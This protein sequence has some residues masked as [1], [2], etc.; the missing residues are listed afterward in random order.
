MMKLEKTQ[1]IQINPIKGYKNRFH[2]ETLKKLLWF[3]GRK[4]DIII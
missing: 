4:S 2:E 3:S 1:G